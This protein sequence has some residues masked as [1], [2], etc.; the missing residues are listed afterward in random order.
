MQLADL[1]WPAVD[2][3][4]RDIPVVFP[5][6]ALEQ[7]G[8]HAPVFTDSMLLGEVVRRASAQMGDRVLWAPLT[9]LGSSDH[10]LDYPGT[11]SASPRLYLDLLNNL[12]ENFLFHG[13]RRLLLINGHG[14]NIVPAQQAVFETRQRHRQQHDLLLLSA[15]YWLLGSKPQELNAGISQ[16]RMGHGCEWETSMVLRL[17]PHLVHDQQNTE[18]VDWGKPFEPANR[19][20]V[21]KDR[22]VP[23]HIGDPRPATAEKGEV[24]FSAF[25]ADVV[26]LLE[27]MIAWDGKSWSG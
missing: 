23:G 26:K 22:S 25:S 11:V 9:W 12:L 18:F 27:R 6:A 17:A 1:P 4:S 7:H 8:L 24:M 16:M 19:G 21:M 13:F 20:W 3:L 5:I 15:T 14:G 10:H 2:A